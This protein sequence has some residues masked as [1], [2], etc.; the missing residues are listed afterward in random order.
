MWTS[1]QFL[2]K[3]GDAFLSGG[4][5]IDTACFTNK[6]LRSETISIEWY[7]AI[8]ILLLLLSLLILLLLLNI[9]LFHVQIK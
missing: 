5:N 2:K 4:C 6:F 3:I 9:I 8:I 1:L 7:N